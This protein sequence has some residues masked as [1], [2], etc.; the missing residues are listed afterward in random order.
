M[1]FVILI[2]KFVASQKLIDVRA[3]LVCVYCF[4]SLYKAVVESTLVPAKAEEE[5]GPASFFFNV[6]GVG[7]NVY[8]CRE[9]L[10]FGERGD[11]S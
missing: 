7:G 1:S 2:K 6:S 8:S 11:P 10:A 3:C 4:S 9:L 5:A